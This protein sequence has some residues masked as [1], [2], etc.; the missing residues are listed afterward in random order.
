MAIALILT[1]TLAGLVTGLLLALV[2]KILFW[3]ND[4][5]EGHG[6]G[7]GGD[8]RR[9][10]THPDPPR[11]PRPSGGGA[12]MTHPPVDLAPILSPIGA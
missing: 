8:W 6:G 1:T 2:V 4:S 10:R 11:P 9:R 3:L 5:D 12:S 7:D